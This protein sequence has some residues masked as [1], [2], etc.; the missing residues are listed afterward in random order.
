MGLIRR[1]VEE[2]PNKDG[3]IIDG[4]PRSLEQAAYFD[5]EVRTRACLFFWGV[6]GVEG[7]VCVP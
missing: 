3:F 4:F 5:A 7:V 6:E 2:E 1:I